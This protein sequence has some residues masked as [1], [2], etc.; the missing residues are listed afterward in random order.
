MFVKNVLMKK[1]KT[2]WYIEPLSSECNRSLA[3]YFDEEAVQK[4]MPT[5]DGPKNLYEARDGYTDVVRY[6]GIGLACNFYQKTKLDGPITPWVPP[7]YLRKRGK[8]KT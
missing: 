7:V 3:D 5:S 8:T 4:V 1:L 2:I 6:C